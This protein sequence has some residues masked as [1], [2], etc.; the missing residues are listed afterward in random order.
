MKARLQTELPTGGDWL[1]EVKLD[2][3]RA[4]VIKDGERVQL[5]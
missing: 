1:F 5:F 2:G 4:L 3:I